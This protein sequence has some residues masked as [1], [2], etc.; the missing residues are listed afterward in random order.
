MATVTKIGD[1]WRAQVRIKGH[2]SRSDTFD[3]KAQAVTWASKAEAEIR[4]GG[5]LDTSALADITIAHLVKRYKE[6]LQHKK[7]FGRSKLGCLSMIERHMGSVTLAAL[8]EDSITAYA[9]KRHALGAGPVTISLD[10]AYMVGIIKLARTVWKIPYKRDPVADARPYLH[11]L[12]LVGKSTERDRR[13]TQ[14]ELNKLCAYFERPRQ[15]IPMADII[16]FAVATAMRSGE[17]MRIRWADLDHENRTV[18]IRDRKHPKEKL[19]NNQT[20]PLLG[21]AYE[22][23]KKQPESGEFIFPYS[24]GS[25]STIFP[26]ACA[27]LGIVDLHFHDLRHEGVSRLFEAGYRIEQVALV[28]GHRD[29]KQLRRYTQVRAK[30]LHRDLGRVVVASAE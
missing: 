28:S 3:K 16:P 15:R 1:R 24:E 4:N 10:L 9:K 27:A 13:P 23:V 17:I 5:F 11:M 7:P 25:I 12:G 29:W 30:D 19:G 6:E 8:N 21:V 26:R 14:D 22:I 2:P 18:I 20:V